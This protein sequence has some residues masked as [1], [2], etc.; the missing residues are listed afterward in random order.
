MRSPPSPSVFNARYI[1][2]RAA[3]ARGLTERLLQAT[4]DRTPA[5]RRLLVPIL[6]R[7]WHRDHEEGWRLLSRIGDEMIRFPGVPYGPAVE[8]FVEVSLAIV[9]NCRGDREQ[10]NRLAGIWREQLEQIFAAPLAR[11]LGQRWVLRMLARPFK[12]VL[13]RQPAYQ[14]FNFREFE[15]TAARPAAFRETWR[16][17]LS[18]LEHPEAGLD[19][20]AQVLGRG[21]IP[22]DLHLMLLCER[23]LVYHG[24]KVDPAATFELLSRLFAKG[25]PW[26][27]QSVLYVVFHQLSNLPA[28]EEIWLDRYVAMADEFFTSGSWRMRSSVAQYEFSDH[29]AWPE[30]VVDRWAPAKAA[31]LVPS[32]LGRAVAAGDAGQ[33]D[34]LFKAVNIIAFTHRRS[35]LALSIL[36]RSLAIG[37]AALEERVL[38]SLATVRLQDQDLV[39]AFIDEHGELSRLRPQLETAAPAIVEED[40]PTLIDGLIVQLILNSDY[41]RSNLCSAFRR[42][43]DAHSAMELLTQLIEWM[44]DELQQLNA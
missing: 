29:F 11:T 3:E 25:C 20:I 19:Q 39:D 34:A 30:L 6:Y 4:R 14:P 36:D 40:M 24:V 43:W 35:P 9:N 42:A 41:F 13:Q 17:A 16:A 28:V 8:V 1:A 37:G 32:L 23:T 33:I 5:V 18:C 22:F 44:R 12:W 21:D 7:A 31:Q 26:F 27:R 15:V 10:L 2:I 38:S